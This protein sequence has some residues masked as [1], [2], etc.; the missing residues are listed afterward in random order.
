VWLNCR[1]T[2]P[3]NTLPSKPNR[4]KVLTEIRGPYY[5]SVTQIYLDELFSDWREYVDGIK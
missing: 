4:K 5:A 3:T 2:L 1:R